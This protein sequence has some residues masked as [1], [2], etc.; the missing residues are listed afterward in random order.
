MLGKL[1][2]LCRGK[3]N[4]RSWYTKPTGKHMTIADLRDPHLWYP[5]AHAMKRKI[6]L[7]VGPTN[8]GKTYNAIQA[9]ASARTAV[10]CGPLRLLAAEIYDKLNSEY[11]VPCSLVTGQQ[12]IEEPNAKHVACT[13]EMADLKQPVDVAI[14]DEYQLISDYQRGWAWTRALLGLQAREIHL[15][16][17]LSRID[18]IQHIADITGDTLEIRQYERLLPLETEK[19]LSGSTE[20]IRAGDAIIAFSRKDV[21]ALKRL[22]ETRTKHKCCV[23]Y[24]NLPPESRKNQA[25]LFNDV[26]SESKVLV[27]TDAIGM[28]LNLNIGR[29]VFSAISKYDGI[30]DRMLT[31]SEVKQ[32]AGRA[33]RYMSEYGV[34]K[35]TS[36]YNQHMKHIK[37]HL[38]LPLV[39]DDKSFAMILPM[40]EQFEMLAEI[41]PE[42]P[43]SEMVKFFME[44]ARTDHN[45]CMA[46]LDTLF[47]KAKCLDELDLSLEDR[48]IFCM[49][50]VD[51]DRGNLGKYFY[52]FASDFFHKNEVNFRKEIPKLDFASPQVRLNMLEELYKICDLYLWLSNRFT[53]FTDVEHVSRVMDEITEEISRILATLNSPKRSLPPR[54][55]RDRRSSGTLRDKRRKAENLRRL[56]RSSN[57]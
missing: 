40:Y 28:G 3:R 1:V 14:I 16:G 11:K 47:K 49:A 2:Q 48:Y 5:E 17:D 42:W 36:L 41:S 34:G 4:A 10:Y 24:G 50:P 44:N 25:D 35:V 23:I 32:I 31:T 51:A 19:G 56:V 18:L 21:F 20:N 46:E 55:S 13:V 53:A 27:G 22:I 57:E 37:K 12:V 26:N 43:F 8:S 7:H 9:L 6:I 30:S 54:R 29:V 52:K 33:G 45:F 15:T 39:P 38:E